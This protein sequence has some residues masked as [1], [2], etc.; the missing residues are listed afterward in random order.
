VYDA[1]GHLKFTLTPYG[2]D[3]RGG[4]RVAT[5]DINGDGTPDIIT[6]AGPG[7]GPLVRVFSGVDGTPLR[8]FYAYDAGF[9]GGIFVA[10][11]DVNGDGRADI[12]IGAGAGGGPHVEAFSGV[13]NALLKS[14]Y[15]YDLGYRGGV[16]VA[17]GDTNGDGKADIVT[18][19]GPG[20]GPHVV[21]YSGTTNNAVLKSFMAY[22]AGFTG[23]VWVAA[24]DVNGDGKADIITGPGAGMA[25]LVKAFSGAG[26]D[27][28]LLRSF[29]AYTPNVTGGVRV[30]AGDLTGD[31]VADII[32]GPGPGGG[33]HVKAFDGV[34]LTV[35]LELMAFDPTYLGGV[36]VG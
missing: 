5:G 14:F 16:V 18:G 22:D 15:A 28:A 12:V 10:V 2:T 7:G 30:A 11:G 6:G 26:T 36:F 3:F 13:N 21:V 1:I 9:P 20:G 25:P 24:G 29:Q 33:P 4:V 35:R 34:D 31:H 19:T 8:T 32:T 27:A 23:G 17:A